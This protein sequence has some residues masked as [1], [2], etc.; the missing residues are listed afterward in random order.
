MSSTDLEVPHYAV[1]SSPLT[2]NPFRVE[3][4]VALIQRIF[5]LP[6]LAQGG[7]IGRCTAK[8]ESSQAMKSTPCIISMLKQG[9]CVFSKAFLD[10]SGSHGGVGEIVTEVNMYV[11]V[12]KA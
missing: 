4:S 10:I 11:S 9:H 5:L 2:I 12:G 1:F 6:D 8:T 7:N 3:T